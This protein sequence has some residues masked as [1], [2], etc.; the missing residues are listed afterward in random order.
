MP[1]KTD[2]K[3]KP[4]ESGA[5]SPTLAVVKKENEAL[6]SQL[7]DQT[8]LVSQEKTIE[9]Q[10]VQ[11][12]DSLGCNISEDQKYQFLNICKVYG[13]NPFIREIYAVAYGGNFNVIVGY[14]VYLKRAER[15][16]QLAGWKVWTEG[17][18]NG[19]VA[20]I[21]IKRKDWSDP[22]CHEVGYPEYVQ[23]KWD[24]DAKAMRPTKFWKTKPKTMLKKV[25]MAQGFRLAFPAELGG[26]PYTADELPDNMSKVPV[27]NNTTPKPGSFLK[28]EAG[29]QKVEDAVPT[30]AEVVDESQDKKP[31]YGQIRLELMDKVKDAPQIDNFLIAKAWIKEKQNIVNLSDDQ[32][33]RFWR[34]YDEIIAIYNNWLKDN[35]K[36][37]AGEGGKK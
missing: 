9:A 16:G 11:Y 36:P 12:L 24:K 34:N 1:T 30:D 35:Y 21:E 13:L 33:L 31:D 19:L 26:M 37:N 4:R 15:S 29:Q 7:R 17:A 25:V 5:P 32:V 6:R 10:A 20:K 23:M 22:F 2:K 27:D 14:E 3:K 8:A 28:S 18:G